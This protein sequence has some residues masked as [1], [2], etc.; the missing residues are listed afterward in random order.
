MIKAV[1]FDI[2]G[3]LLDSFEANLKFFQTLMMKVGYP[4]P[5]RLGFAAVFHLNMME[6]IKELTK[7]SSA[8]EIKKIWELGRSRE[9]EYDLDLL[10]TPDGAVEVIH[11]LSESYLL[12]IVTSRI[13]ESVYEVPQLR[14]LEKYFKVVVSYQDT[15]NHKPHPEPLLLAAQK[16]ALKPEECIYIGDAESDVKAARAAG[17]KIIGFTKKQLNLADA[18]TP[19]FTMLPALISSLG[20]L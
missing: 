12:G 17:M 9:V 5:T 18:C 3:V 20:S 7:S 2:D 10:L 15:E 1:I 4:P 14:K 13:R 8:D 6:V 16:L 19:T 11:R